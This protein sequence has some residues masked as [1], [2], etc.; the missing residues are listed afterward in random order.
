MIFK[1]IEEAVEFGLFWQKIAIKRGK[2]LKDAMD[3]IDELDDYI[4][5]L[6]THINILEVEMD[7]EV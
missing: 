6:E 1:T 5:E 2:A 7:E 3:K 4:D